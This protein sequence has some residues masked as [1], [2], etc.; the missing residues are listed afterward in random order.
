MPLRRRCCC[1]ADAAAPPMLLYRLCCCSAYATVCLCCCVP[2]TAAMCSSVHDELPS[3]SEQHEIKRRDAGGDLR[4]RHARHLQGS[5][6]QAYCWGRKGFWCPELKTNNPGKST[7]A[8]C[9]R[10]SR[11]AWLEYHYKTKKMASANKAEHH[12][13]SV[14]ILNGL[15]FFSTPKCLFLDRAIGPSCFWPRHVFFFDLQLFF[16]PAMR[17][18][19]RAQS[20]SSTSM[21]YFEQ[22]FPRPRNIL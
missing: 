16:S 22:S 15:L 21:H 8:K 10:K 17:P 14:S 9:Y 19:K 3:R 4:V 2:P 7:L 18:R 20:F 12:R 11:R 1:A 13:A 6:S 5:W